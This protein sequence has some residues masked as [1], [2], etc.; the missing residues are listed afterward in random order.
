LSGL[1]AHVYTESGPGE[2]DPPTVLVRN[3][4]SIYDRRSRDVMMPHIEVADVSLTY[5]TPSGQG[6]GVEGVSIDI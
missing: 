6:P 4:Q 5:D 1:L 2:T 3:A